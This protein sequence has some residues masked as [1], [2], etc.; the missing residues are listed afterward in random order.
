MSAFKINWRYVGM[1]VA[2]LVFALALAALY[3]I[4]AE[5]HLADVVTRIRDTS[6]LSVV[7]ALAEKKL[8]KRLASAAS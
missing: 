6:L 8:V 2:L 4:L 1:A 5:V 3:H 7:I